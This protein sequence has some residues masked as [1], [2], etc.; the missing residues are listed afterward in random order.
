MTAGPG[1]RIGD[2]ERNATAE[3]LREHYAAGR[4]DMDEF[5]ERLDATFAAKTDADLASLTED[6][7]HSSP[8]TAPWPAGGQPTGS[9]PAYPVSGSQQ[10]PQGA[11]G[12][13]RVLTGVAFLISFYVL[14]TV[15]IVSL[16]FGGPIKGILFA[17]SIIALVRRLLRRIFAGGRIGGCRR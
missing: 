3:S 13:A 10:A 4:L 16:P 17:L 15:V 9:L 11:A 12:W 2:A 14:A 6:L 5:Q 1:I 8:Y 7:P